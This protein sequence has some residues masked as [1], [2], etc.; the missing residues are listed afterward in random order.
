MKALTRQTQRQ[1]MRAFYYD[2][3][4][5]DDLPIAAAAVVYNGAVLHGPGR[6]AK[7]LQS[8][9]RAQGLNVDVDGAIGPET[10]GAVRQA[11]VAAVVRGYL[12][13]EAD[14]LR[15]LE[16]FPTFGKG[17]MN[18]LEDIRKFAE[19]LLTEPAALTV[20]PARSGG[21][22]AAAPTPSPNPGRSR[23]GKNLLHP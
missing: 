13:L 4:R 16:H 23:M 22:A 10:L 17:W 3:V 18:R 1:I 21:A 9:L 7:F 14:F 5:G 8:S 19:T 11:N 15:G 6:S 2:V 12:S 20:C